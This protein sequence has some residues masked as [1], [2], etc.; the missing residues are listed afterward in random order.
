MVFTNKGKSRKALRTHY[1]Y[2]LFLFYFSSDCNMDVYDCFVEN[3]V[4]CTLI[5]FQKYL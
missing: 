1:I 5:D 4:E 3:D 2:Q